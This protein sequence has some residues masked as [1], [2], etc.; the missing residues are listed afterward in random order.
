MI[1]MGRSRKPAGMQMAGGM[2]T[3]EVEA[4]KRKVKDGKEERGNAAE[5]K[6]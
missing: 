4:K 2:K 5:R 6:E 1:A 3:G